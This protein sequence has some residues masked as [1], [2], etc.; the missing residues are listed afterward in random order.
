MNANCAF[1]KEWP[2]KANAINQ[3]KSA[4]TKALRKLTKK[5]VTR[6]AR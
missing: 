2:F 6:E 1:P 4:A 5:A 3:P